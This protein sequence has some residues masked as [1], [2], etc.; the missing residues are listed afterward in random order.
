MLIFANGYNHLMDI[1]FRKKL[2]EASARVSA[3]PE[4]KK[5]V[6]QN[7]F[8]SKNDKP[9]E[10][11]IERLSEPDQ[12]KLEARRV[13]SQFSDWAYAVE[14]Y[15]IGT[16]SGSYIVLAHYQDDPLEDWINRNMD[17]IETGFEH[18]ALKKFDWH[19]HNDNPV[20]A[21]QEC[22]DKIRQYYFEVLSG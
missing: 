8:K 15:V 16:Q 4:W 5:N 9:R 14:Y 7:S 2:N 21:M 19:G 20:I 12:E 10:P 22:Y 1:E 17:D 11:I 3:W 18:D 13:E 6:L